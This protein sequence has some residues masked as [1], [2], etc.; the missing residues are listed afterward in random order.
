MA[1]TSSMV[2]HSGLKQPYIVAWSQDP[3]VSI[4]WPKTFGCRT[5]GESV[6]VLSHLIT[7]IQMLLI[8]LIRRTNIS[9]VPNSIDIALSALYESYYFIFT[10]ST[11]QDTEDWITCPRSSSQPKPNEDFWSRS[12]CP[13]GAGPW[14][15]GSGSGGALLGQIGRS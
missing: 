14:A 12:L 8:T 4:L 5:A 3:G 1:H 6:A 9:C 13:L 11:L 15:L 2:T 7:F 10:K